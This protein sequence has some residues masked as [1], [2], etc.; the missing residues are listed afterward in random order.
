LQGF[1]LRRFPDS[2][3]CRDGTAA[4]AVYWGDARSNRL[5]IQVDGTRT[6]QCGTASEL[7]AG[8]AKNVPHDPKQRCVSIDIDAMRYSI[9]IDGVGH[10]N[11]KTV[12]DRMSI[13]QIFGHCAEAILGRFRRGAT[14]ILVRDT[15]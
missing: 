9:D 13:D 4:D 10:S 11:L 5:T 8:H 3:D 14:E 2:L 7:R 1:S 12:M 15:T 6:A